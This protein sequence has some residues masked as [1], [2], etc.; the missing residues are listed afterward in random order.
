MFGHLCLVVSLLG[1][2]LPPEEGQSSPSNPPLN[3]GGSNSGQGNKQAG[4]PQMPA[5]GGS[6]GSNGGSNNTTPG[7][8][9]SP[10]TGGAPVEG[11]PAGGILLDMEQMSAQMKQDEIQ[12]N[13][14]ITISGKIQGECAGEV[15]VDVIDT[16]NLGG[17]TEG[18][19]LSGPI[20]TMVL[21]GTDEFAILVPTGRSVNL[22][23]LC[24]G[25]KNGKI[26]AEEDKLSQGAR[27]GV[28]DED[29]S[30]VLLI[31]EAIQPPKGGPPENLQEQ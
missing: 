21:E 28:V 5:G 26:T 22:T 1:C 20:T 18:G 27:L 12:T 31:L 14:H 7:A 25:D 9:G 11:Q 17:P 29:T 16:S 23:A 2:P 4:Q 24:D 10:P 13:E 19:E 6:P 15:R 3:Q 8:G 30:D